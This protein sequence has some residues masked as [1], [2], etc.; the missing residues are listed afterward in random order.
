MAPSTAAAERIRAVLGP[1][2]GVSERRMFGGL[3]FL[4]GGHMCCGLLGEDLVLRLGDEAAAAA[5]KRRHVRPMDFTGRPMK[6]MVYVAPA[7]YRSRRALESWLGRALEFVHG[8]PPKRAASAPP[9]RRARS[10]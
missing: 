8:L 1:A 7:G 3:A 9:V 4:V 2:A 10:R 6:S 5:L